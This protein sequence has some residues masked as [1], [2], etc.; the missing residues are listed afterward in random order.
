M[1]H[2]NNNNLSP[3]AAIMPNNNTPAPEEAWKDSNAKKL[4]HDDIV[5]GAVTDD[6]GPSFVYGMRTEYQSFKYENFRNNLRSLRES[7]RNNQARANDDESAFQHDVRLRSATHDATARWDRSAAKTM[8]RQEIREGRVDGLT[9]TEIWN[10]NVEYQRFTLSKFSNH[11]NQEKKSFK[12]SSYWKYNN[13]K[14]EKKNKKKE[15]E[16]IIE[17][18]Y[19]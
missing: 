9:P 2:T 16:I 14:K 18:F 12:A 15:D 4:L 3:P 7:I 6:I 11:L 8:L 10:G 19:E 17:G 1:Y 13:N 5:S